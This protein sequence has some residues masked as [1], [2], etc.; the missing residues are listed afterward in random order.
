MRPVSGRG[1]FFQ[2]V[3]GYNPGRSVFDLSYERHLTCKYGLLYPVWIQEALPGDYLEYSVDALIRMQP[4]ISPVM[5]KITAVA[6]SFFIPKRLTMYN[7]ERYITRGKDG[8]TVVEHPTWP[9]IQ[10]Q[11]GQF[12]TGNWTYSYVNQVDPKAALLEPL[13][14]YIPT[15]S[16]LDVDTLWDHLGLPIRVDRQVACPVVDD[17]LRRSYYLVWNDYYRDENLISAIYNINGDGEDVEYEVFE[18]LPHAACYPVMDTQ[19]NEITIF[20]MNWLMPRAWRKD[21]FTSALPFAQRGTAP[22][23]PLSGTASAVWSRDN[24]K[25]ASTPTSGARNIEF[26]GSPSSPVGPKGIVGLAG[27][28]YPAET[29]AMQQWFNNNRVDLTNLGTFTIPDFYLAYSTQKWMEYQARGGARYI[30]TLQSQW[31]VSPSDARLQRPEYIG[32]CKIPVVV[33]EVVQTSGDVGGTPQGNMAGHGMA[34][35]GEY[36]GSYKAEEYGWFMTLLS[37][38][39]STGYQ[40]GIPREYSRLNAFE[41]VWPIFANLSE[42]GIKEREIFVPRTTTQAV[43]YKPTRIFGFQGRYNECRVR[44]NEVTGQMRVYDPSDYIDG[45]VERPTVP[46]PASLSYWNFARYFSARPLLNWHFMIQQ[47][48]LDNQKVLDEPPFIVQWANMV[49]MVRRLPYTAIPG[50]RG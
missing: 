22:A 35:G 9:Q 33:S 30:E 17:T 48:R 42:Q 37:F 34:V 41:E 28:L 40:Q 25:D 47:P 1:S 11:T 26:F 12:T 21:Y 50:L 23:I 16:A 43:D 39:V 32:G 14:G 18:E 10:S 19:N 46:V 38:E 24:F 20:V 36:I 44:Q 7:F 49:R 31:G 6:H 15:T 45:Y 4:T 27:D 29:A 3:Q 13:L 2:E 8:N 5:G